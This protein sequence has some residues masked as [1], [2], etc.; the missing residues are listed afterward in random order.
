V[1]TSDLSSGG[2]TL[3]PLRS[4]LSGAQRRGARRQPSCSRYRQRSMPDQEGPTRAFTLIELLIV[5][6]ILAILAALLFP[7]FARAREKARQVSCAAHLRQLGLALAMY[8]PDYDD[9]LPKSYFG[10][11]TYPG[12]Y[13]W[14]DVLQPYT[15]NVQ[16]FVCPSA[17]TA[18]YAPNTL[19]RYGGYA[20]NR[21]YFGSDVPDGQETQP[22]FYY[23]GMPLAEIQLPSRTLLLGDGG[24]ERFEA[25][26]NTKNGQPTRV[27]AG[28]RGPR[29]FAY[30][31]TPAY[32]ARHSQD[33]NFTYCDEHVK[34]QKL[35]ALL[36][37][38]ANG[39]YPVFTVEDD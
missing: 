35:D 1:N 14:M 29:L 22:P 26:W 38:N 23:N 15:R 37:P 7:V 12:V 8:A 6:T 17:G 27:L 32:E 20:A 18:V 9:M 28:P 5:I 4:F 34:W 24:L 36:K 25:A 3:Q 16:L 31:T 2:M 39:I 10:A 13:R 11:P 19:N 30:D 33:A 21:A